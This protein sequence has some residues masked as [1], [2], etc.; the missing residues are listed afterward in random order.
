M[1][2]NI[3]NYISTKHDVFYKIEMVLL[4]VS[5]IVYVFP[6]TV[7]FK[8]SYQ[9]NK[10]W[11]H[12]DLIAP[13]DF[14][15][16]KTDK[17]ITDEQK[18]LI[19]SSKLY[20]QVDPTVFSR[21]VE[22]F[23]SVFTQEAA[24]IG[25]KSKDKQYELNKAICLALL[26]EIYGKGILESNQQLDDKTTDY[27]IYILK[28]NIAEEV[29]INQ[30]FT[31]GTAFNYLKSNIKQTSG[32]SEKL[33]LRVFENLLQHNII[34][35]AT[36]TTKAQKEL[37]D[38]ISLSR[39]MKQQ[40]ERIISRGDIVNQEK[41]KVLE[42]LKAEYISQTG[43]SSNLLYIMSGQFVLVL[44]SIMLLIIFLSLF[45]KD[46]LADN[47]ILFFILLNI[48]LTAAMVSLSL[49][50][51][52]TNIYMLPFCIYPILVRSFF[53][54]RVALFMHL[55]ST[56]I[57][58]IIA[59]SPFEFVFIQLAAGFFAVF[60]IIDM[61][62]RS[63]LFVTVGIIFLT[64]CLAFIA[65][66][67][68]LDGTLKNVN[69][70]TL[71]WF[72]VSA[73]SILFVYPLI[74]IFEKLFGFVSEVTLMELSD[75]NSPL[76]RELALKAPGTFQHSLQVA[77]LAEEAIIAIGGSSLL[78]RT[79]ALYHDIGK[80]DMPMYF[81]ENQSTDVNPHNEL[82][83]EDS[84]TIITGHVHKGIE[85]AKENNLPDQLIDFIRTHHGTTK[86]QY[87]YQSFLKNFPDEEI[88][89]SLFQYPGPIPFS[90]ETAVLMMSD[91]VE[92]ASRS[93]K[94]YDA[95]SLEKLVDRV[96]DSQIAQN[97]FANADITFKNIT[98]IKRIFK[99][100][101]SNIY[102]LRI[103]YPQ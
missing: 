81:I 79:G 42:S 19:E 63:Q 32:V 35:D 40:G 96:I 34:F 41:F 25:I 43:G 90:K 82:S 51:R 15:I 70:Y 55:S 85:I 29:E 72:G 44:M 75:I 103:E 33:V 26:N 86:A 27:S 94:H 30:L 36:T 21:I 64:Y 52:I 22:K 17:E 24:A 53:D 58:G 11:L 47:K 62:H 54:T 84:A 8:Y 101:L 65:Y 89:V 93:L 80:M 74:F 78:V 68:M 5:V 3:K 66:T 20:F 100:K 16:N 61:H 69:W 2:A 57:L 4:C 60:S 48:V 23:P 92:A 14:G 88:D 56:L 59:P 28:N 50:F 67:V 95:E 46:M 9:K 37:L 83:F 38:N 99:K 77:N 10:P 91:S 13:F 18:E 71:Q 98:V 6:K 31:I 87:F 97:Q 1:L 49:R 39:D 73:A 7:K 102:H 12:E 76:L 45:R